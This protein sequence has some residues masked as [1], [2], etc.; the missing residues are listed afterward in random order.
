VRLHHVGQGPGDR[1][2]AGAILEVLN[3]ARNPGV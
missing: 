3:G 1:P 2:S